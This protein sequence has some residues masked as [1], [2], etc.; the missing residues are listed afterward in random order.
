MHNNCTQHVHTKQLALAE[1]LL[2]PAPHCGTVP[3]PAAAV[4]R[5]TPARLAAGIL[6]GLKGLDSYTRAAETLAFEIARED[7]VAEAG[8]VLESCLL[9]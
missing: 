1:S 5:L 9:A 6:A 7:G 3:R 4:K 2:A 8:A